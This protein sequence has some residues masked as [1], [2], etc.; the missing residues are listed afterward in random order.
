VR[1]TEKRSGNEGPGMSKTPLKPGRV[2]TSSLSSGVYFRTGN[3]DIVHPGL[4]PEVEVLRE[5]CP[6]VQNVENIGIYRRDGPH[7]SHS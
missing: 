4:C 7:L 5:R 3:V 6:D 2:V 1:K